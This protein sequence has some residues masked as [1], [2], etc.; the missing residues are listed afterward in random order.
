M[1]HRS[2]QDRFAFTLV[3][4]LVVIV[5]IG[6]I[7]ALLLPV[8][9]AARE[10]ARRTRCQANLRQV[11]L[12]MIQYLDLHKETFPDAAQMPSV[13]PEKPSLYVTLS[14]LIEHNQAV[15]E[16]PSDYEVFSREGTSYEYRNSRLAGRTTRE[17]TERR[18]LSEVVVLFDFENFHGPE[19][20]VGSRNQLFADGH[21]TPL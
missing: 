6:L 16:C 13:T 18:K 11:G 12:S 21:V 19:G 8:I 4:L 1:T 15:F 3:E 7:I 14:S 17:V 5:I 20:T 10:T 9:N 2:S